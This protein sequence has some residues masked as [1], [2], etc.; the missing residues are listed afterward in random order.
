[1]T[2]QQ[3]L[4]ALAQV[5]LAYTV[6]AV[7]YV[8]GCYVLARKFGT[9]VLPIIWLGISLVVGGVA[10]RRVYLPYN[11]SGPIH[12]GQLWIAVGFCL[13][14]FLAFGLAT[15][16]VRAGLRRSPGARLH[17]GAVGRGV[18]AFFFGIAMVLVFFLVLD[19]RRLLS[20]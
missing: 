4:I 16:S 1:M 18:L 12:W 7:L 10:L 19:V 11:V 2:P 3:G 6:L 20:P 14:F 5:F 13:M 15:L 9:R 17:V 8:V